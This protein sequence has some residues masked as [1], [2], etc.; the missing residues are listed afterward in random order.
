LQRGAELHHPQLR[1]DPR[2]EDVHPLSPCR[3]GPVRHTFTADATPVGQLPVADAEPGPEKRLVLHRTTYRCSGDAD[4]FAPGGI[5]AVYRDLVAD[6]ARL[7]L[8]VED[9]LE[10]V[11][12]SR[13]CLVLTQWTAHVDRLATQLTA[14]GHEPV[15]L[16][17]GMGARA[18]VAAMVRLDP[19]TSDRPLLVVATGP[20]AGEGFDCPPLD[21]LFLAAPISF[22]GRLVQY[23]SRIL[24]P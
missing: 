20:Y 22:S 15:V 17:G 5:A 24:R 2:R 23:A 6:D 4:P 14:R 9:V 10:A 7:A 12:R 18:R 16:V 13:H 11:V 1:R 19:G 3:E 8:V 21:A